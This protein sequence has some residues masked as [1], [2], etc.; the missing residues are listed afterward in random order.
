MWK[1][2]S[3]LLNNE[4][5]KEEMTQEIRKYI[6]KNENTAYQNLRDTVK[7]IFHGKFRAVNAYIKKRKTSN[8]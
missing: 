3:T 4:W 5:V 2:N 1:L 6:E 7:A 8:Q